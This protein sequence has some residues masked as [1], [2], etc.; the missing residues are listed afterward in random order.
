MIANIVA[1]IAVSKFTNVTEEE[2][3]NR[4]Q[5]FVQ[6]V[7]EN[8]VVEVKKTKRTLI[9]FMVFGVAV[10]VALILLWVMPY[11]SAL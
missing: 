4:E 3:K 7:G 2:R 11:Y 8:D 6:P 10:T 5:L 1:M 9:V